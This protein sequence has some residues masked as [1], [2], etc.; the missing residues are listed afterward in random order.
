LRPTRS[1]SAPHNGEEKVA[2][3]AVVVSSVPAIVSDAPKR[4]ATKGS[5]GMRIVYARIPKNVIP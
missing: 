5:S 4:F 2:N 3:R 1:L